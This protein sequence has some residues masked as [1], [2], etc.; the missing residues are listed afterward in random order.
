MAWTQQDLDDLDSAIASGALRVAYRDK[1]VTYR[2][3]AEM[4]STR[5]LIE[6]ALAGNRGGRKFTLSKHSKGHGNLGRADRP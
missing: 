5:Q 1:V 3:L 4:L 2:S 6:D